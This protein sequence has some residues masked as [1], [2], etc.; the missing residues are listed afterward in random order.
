MSLPVIGLPL[1]G[2]LPSQS[3]WLDEA[4][5]TRGARTGLRI[6]EVGARHRAVQ[7]GGGV[8]LLPCFLGDA[9]PLLTRLLDPPEAL[10]EDVHLVRHEQPGNPAATQAVV[11][12]LAALFRDQG[13]ALRGDTEKG[14]SAGI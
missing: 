3:R 14:N 1:T 10:T 7:A 11:E 5:A 2:R 8:S 9:D 6:A 4:A 13:G 12:I